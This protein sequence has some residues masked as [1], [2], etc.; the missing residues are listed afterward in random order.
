MGNM[1][2]DGD[3]VLFPVDNPEETLQRIYNA[4][5]IC[6]DCGNVGQLGMIRLERVARVSHGD[7]PGPLRI[8]NRGRCVPC[9]IKFANALRAEKR[10]AGRKS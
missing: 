7:D 6:D 9:A 5:G 4:P 3:E 8:T 10:G 1:G 2:N